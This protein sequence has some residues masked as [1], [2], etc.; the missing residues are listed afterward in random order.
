[1]IF[2]LLRNCC[3]CGLRFKVWKL[4]DGGGRCW[5]SAGRAGCGGSGFWPGFGFGGGS[6]SF[7]DF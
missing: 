5:G 6:N 7:V 2:Y 1:M 4:S 3:W